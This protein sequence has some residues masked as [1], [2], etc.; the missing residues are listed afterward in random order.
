MRFKKEEKKEK[1]YHDSIFPLVSRPFFLSICEC[2]IL[3]HLQTSKP[4][5]GQVLY[6]EYCSVCTQSMYSTLYIK[7][8]VD[9]L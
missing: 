7:N 9:Y 3:G 5:D 4:M 6:V 8:Q 1:E 2:L